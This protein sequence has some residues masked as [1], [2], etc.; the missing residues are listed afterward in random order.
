M[1]RLTLKGGITGKFYVCPSSV[2]DEIQKWQD[3]T[4]YI[5]VIFDVY[6]MDKQV[7]MSV[8]LD[9]ALPI[10]RPFM[11]KIKVVPDT[12]LELKDFIANNIGMELWLAYVKNG[13][14]KSVLA[15]KGTRLG[16]FQDMWLTTG[17]DGVPRTMIVLEERGTFLTSA[18]STP[19]YDATYI[20]GATPTGDKMEGLNN[21]AGPWPYLKKLGLDIEKLGEEMDAAEALWPGHI[22]LD[23][24]SI[25]SFFS[26][27]ENIVP[28]IVAAVY[29]HGRKLVQWE[30]HDDP[31]YG[32]S[33]VKDGIWFDL[34]PVVMADSGEFDAEKVRALENWDNLTR[35]VLNKDVGFMRGSS[36]TDDGRYM[37]K[38][39]LVPL[40]QAH[41]AIVTGVKPDGSPAVM[42]PITQ[43]DWTLDGLVALNMAVEEMFKKGVEFTDLTGVFDSNDSSKLVQWV[44]DNVPLFWFNAEKEEF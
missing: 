39:F 40:V 9:N 33:V 31:E 10:L 27:V 13:W 41:P 12:E 24:G 35:A 16:Y 38:H 36:L 42:F 32:A 25:P 26:N 22:D 18:I 17:K 6:E 1:S 14:I 30:V 29:R 43:E 34:Q 28:D 7:S 2:T 20:K 44:R 4:P 19:W 11:P 15:E 8:P 21:K 5:R 23:R 3:G 37:V